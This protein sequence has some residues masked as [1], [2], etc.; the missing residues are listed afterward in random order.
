MHSHQDRPNIIGTQIIVQHLVK[1]CNLQ[2][3]NFSFELHNM[4]RPKAKC[5]A[6]I[7]DTSV[8]SV[9]ARGNFPS[10]EPCFYLE[11]MLLSN[12]VNVLD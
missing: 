8:F 10:V 3:K 6:F 11:M 7:C 1:G 2:H 9:I 5:H 12:S 4:F